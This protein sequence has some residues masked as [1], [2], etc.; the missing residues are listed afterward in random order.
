MKTNVWKKPKRGNARMTTQASCGRA[1]GL[2]TGPTSIQQIANPMK[3]T[4]NMN[5]LGAFSHVYGIIRATIR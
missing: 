1:I 5:F 4:T 3:L 2:S